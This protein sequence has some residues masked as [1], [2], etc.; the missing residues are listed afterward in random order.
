VAGRIPALQIQQLSDETVIS[1][2]SNV[3]GAE[4]SWPPLG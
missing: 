3:V 2:T 1:F 4:S